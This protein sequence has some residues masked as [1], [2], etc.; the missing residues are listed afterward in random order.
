LLW[1]WGWRW[2]W[3]GFELVGVGIVWHGVFMELAEVEDGWWWHS[4]MIG[5]MLETGSE[6]WYACAG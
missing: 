2:V 4:G 6:F 5:S 1:R 3:L